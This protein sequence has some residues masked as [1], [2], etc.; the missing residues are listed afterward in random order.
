VFALQD[1]L[2]LQELEDLP[3]SPRHEWML[4]A[5]SDRLLRVRLE[6]A[7][8]CVTMGDDE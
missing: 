3:L 7:R 4:G 8:R 5:A 1:G 6:S 2:H